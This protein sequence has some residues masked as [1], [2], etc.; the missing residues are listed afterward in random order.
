[1]E[2]GVIL[3]VLETLP[4]MEIDEHVG[5]IT[6]SSV[7]RLSMLQRVLWAWR[8]FFGGIDSELD[9]LM[10]QTRKDALSK[11]TDEAASRGANAVVSLRFEVARA[12]SGY[13]EVQ[14]YGSAIKV[15]SF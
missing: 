8:N 11:L 6:A 1:M 12:D 9:N 5:L 3:S 7:R 14:V 15:S 2:N 13:C 4:S 10:S